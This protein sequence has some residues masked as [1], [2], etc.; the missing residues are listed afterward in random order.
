MRAFVQCSL[1]LGSVAAIL[2][3]HALQPPDVAPQLPQEVEEVVLGRSGPQCE[4]STFT[5]FEQ[6]NNVARVSGT[7]SI[8]MC[9]AGTTGR[10]TLVANVRGDAGAVTPLEFSE[11]WQRADTQDHIFNADYP[12][13]ENVT[14]TSVRVRNLTCTCESPA[15]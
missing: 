2:S 14:L 6:R 11:T 15:R 9:P 13:G 12:I 7:V 4:A 10:F 8:S 3:G 5:E 1:S